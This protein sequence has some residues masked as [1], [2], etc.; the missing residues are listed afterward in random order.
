MGLA[1]MDC[2][3]TGLCLPQE[4]ANAQSAT[5]KPAQAIPAQT[6][7]V[8]LRS[9]DRGTHIT[10]SLSCLTMGRD[11]GKGEVPQSNSLMEK[12]N[13]Q[14]QHLLSARHGGAHL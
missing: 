7:V 4:D 13:G 9:L 8:K 6:W 11:G 3:W 14:F 10:Y 5:E 1:R 2:V 12:W